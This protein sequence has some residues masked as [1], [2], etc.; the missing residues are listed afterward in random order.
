MLNAMKLSLFVVA[1]A[2]SLPFVC[3]A[4]HQS[5]YGRT[6]SPITICDAVRLPLGK[7]GKRVTFEAEYVSDRIELSFL[8]DQNCPDIIVE[9]FDGP[10]TVKDDAYNAFA[11]M[12]NA[13]PLRVG[14]ITAHVTV[15]GTLRKHGRKRY[16][17]DVVRYINSSERKAR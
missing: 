15:Y 14:S 11:S 13:N 4:A 2:T 8:Q 10:R 16:R 17:L 12:L 9:P 5:A 6:G 1:S 7:H 3:A